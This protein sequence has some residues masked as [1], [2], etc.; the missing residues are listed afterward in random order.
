MSTPREQE[1]EK[2]DKDL[3][4]ADRGA[5]LVPPGPPDATTIVIL[6]PP[7]ASWRAR[8]RRD[9]TELEIRLEEQA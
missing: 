6:L 8:R 4:V 5:L 1:D 7:T 3:E 2:I 9:V